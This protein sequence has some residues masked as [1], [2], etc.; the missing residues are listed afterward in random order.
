MKI[1]SLFFTIALLFLVAAGCLGL[2]PENG[3]E[4]LGGFQC[5]SGHLQ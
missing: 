4:R 2:T 5:M 3:G 1:P